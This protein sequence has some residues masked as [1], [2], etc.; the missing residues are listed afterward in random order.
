MSLLNSSYIQL[1]WLTSYSLMDLS[2]GKH[3]DLSNTGGTNNIN[4]CLWYCTYG[5]I[6]TPKWNSAIINVISYTFA[7]PA[8]RIQNVCSEKYL[9]QCS[10]HQNVSTALLKKYQQLQSSTHL[11]AFLTCSMHFMSY[12]RFFSYDTMMGDVDDVGCV[13]ESPQA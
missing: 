1:N 3:V 5:F 6:D 7:F 4:K 9:L 11:N 8:M 13:D 12:V 10:V 2:H